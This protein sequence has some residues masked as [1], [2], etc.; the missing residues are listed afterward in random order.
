MQHGRQREHVQG[1]AREVA[2]ATLGAWAAGFRKV[3]NSPFI[4]VAIPVCSDRSHSVARRL[5]PTR[6]PAPREH[7]TS[8]SCDP[9]PGR[10][11]QVPQLVRHAFSD[12][13]TAWK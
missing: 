2:H 8:T 11:G 1:V 4:K 10:A 13:K 5:N 9:S 3:L 12:L 6:G 7:G